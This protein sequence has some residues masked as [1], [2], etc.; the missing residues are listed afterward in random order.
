[1]A[2]KDENNE[3]P[4]ATGENEAPQAANENEGLIPVTKAGETLYVNP[5]C[6]A[7]HVAVGWQV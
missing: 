5:A 3:T 2:K 7:A 1:M 4:A 6:V